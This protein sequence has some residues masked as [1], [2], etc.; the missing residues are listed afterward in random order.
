MDTLAAEAG[1]EESRIIKQKR[2]EI[3][4]DGFNNSISDGPKGSWMHAAFHVATAIATP[5]AYAPLPSA[6]A[7]LGWPGGVVSLVTG[8]MVTWYSS[9]LLSSLWKWNGVQ[10][11]TY[12][13]LAQSIF[14]TKGYWAVTFFQQL[15]SLGSNIAIQIAAGSSLKAIYK[16]YHNSG[17]LTLQEFIILFGVFEL[18][19]SQFPDIHS[20]RWV[21]SIC[22]FSTV[23]FAA[24]AIGVS[25]YDGTHLY[26]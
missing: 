16:H 26:P 4:D 12:R 23:G 25:L 2:E 1:V 15:A 22:T 21:N 19:L 17:N 18:F 8:T 20:L 24:T 6:I 3:D 10:H 11:T 7:S 9:F 5:A 14:G 13:K